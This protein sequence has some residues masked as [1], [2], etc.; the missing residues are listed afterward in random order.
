ML[1]KPF[2]LITPQLLTKYKLPTSIFQLTS[3]FTT[4]ANSNS[5]IYNDFGTGFRIA[6]RGKLSF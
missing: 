1:E 4:F 6:S 2:S 5:N 3:Y